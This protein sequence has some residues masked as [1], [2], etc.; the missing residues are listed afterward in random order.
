MCFGHCPHLVVVGTVGNEWAT[1]RGG[2]GG[3]PGTPEL[4]FGLVGALGADLTHLG[5]ILSDALTD[6][7]Y[8]PDLIRVSQLLHEIPEWSTLPD[9]PLEQQIDKHQKA[10]NELRRRTGLWGAMAA[11]AMTH[12]QGIRK[13][14]GGD[15]TK[16]LPN[17]AYVIRS[18]KHPGE[19]DLLRRVYG[20]SFVLIAAYAPHHFRE[21]QLA[22]AIATSHRSG[23]PGDFLAE[24][25][26]L[27]QTD[28]SEPGREYGQRVRDTFPLADVFFNSHRPADL[29]KE[30]ERFVEI[31]FGHPFRTPTRDEFAMF[32]ARAAALR[33]A[34]LSR[35]VGAVIATTDADVVAVGAN[36][37]PRGTGGSYWEGDE[38]DSRDFQLGKNVSQD[39]RD[40]ALGE[41]LTR[42]D[43]EGL[44]FVRKG[45]RLESV[46][47]RVSAVMGDTLLM[48]TGEFGRAVH[49]EMSALLDAARRGASVDGKTMY[50]T[51][52]PCHNCAK[53]LIAAGISRV[54]YIEPF[55]KSQAQRLHRDAI[56]VDSD[57]PVP[58]KVNFEPFVGVAPSRYL[59]FFQMPRRKTGT[60]R[61]VSWR[62]K[63]AVPRFAEPWQE[64]T[65]AL[66]ENAIILELEE[67]IGRAR[68]LGS[69]R[70][71]GT[72][73][74]PKRGGG[75]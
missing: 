73:G 62:W 3:S 52:F 55:P 58:G 6:M 37:V 59:D 5:S 35:Q 30:I 56:V 22:S 16:P 19:V 12:I 23:R 63:G 38:G 32:H 13:K 33:S 24:A 48:N 39:L 40:T 66:A 29:K 57:S 27:I 1:W 69:R 64:A 9:Q 65:R 20:T 44:L 8:Q 18:L 7:G 42:L 68:L 49:A 25:Q 4:V 34:D 36:E 54:V 72:R 28:E 14:E 45:E 71:A 67:A 43:E 75:A 50:T 74:K 70:R 31:L 60:G 17:R 46:V 41:V 26:R 15:P 11:L 21:E 53:H 10:G 61:P 47:S 2:M 51:T